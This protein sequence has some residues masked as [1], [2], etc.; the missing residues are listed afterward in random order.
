MIS[1]KGSIWLLSSTLEANRI[2]LMPTKFYSCFRS[3]PA[4]SAHSSIILSQNITTLTDAAALLFSRVTNSYQRM[5][6]L[7]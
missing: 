2:E 3:T 6:F 5:P 1:D 4:S 7:W